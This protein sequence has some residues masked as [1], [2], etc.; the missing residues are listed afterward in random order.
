MTP[1]GEPILP[2]ERSVA[3]RDAIAGLVLGLLYAA[4]LPVAVFAGLFL[5][6][7]FA[8]GAASL[9]A[10]ALA[11][12]GTIAPPARPLAFVCALIGLWAVASSFWSPAAPESTVAAL[13][14]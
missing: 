11:G 3:T 5:A 14:L 12:R 9:A 13:R 8:V 6:P 4:G 1:A 2:T 10:L 7:L